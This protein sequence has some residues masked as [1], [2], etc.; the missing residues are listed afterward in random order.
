MK[1]RVLSVLTIAALSLS[2]CA[3]NEYGQK[4]QYGT[5]IGGVLGGVLGAQIGDGRGQLA[6]T[7]AGA[8]LGTILGS[9]VGKSLDKADLVYANQ[10]FDNAHNAPMGQTISWNNP[11]TGN[12]G[13]YQPVRDGYASDGEY[14][15]EYQQTIIVDGRQEIGYGTAC[16]NPDGSWQII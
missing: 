6:A 9:Q 4:E 16:Q 13:T 3:S 1:K 15:R 5:V 2:A 8:M 12:S 14:C 10:A 7:A 11:D